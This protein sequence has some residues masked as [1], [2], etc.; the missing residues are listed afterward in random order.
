MLTTAD[1]A[2]ATANSANN[3]TLKNAA[4]DRIAFTASATPDG[5]AQFTQGGTIDYLSPS[6]L[7]L[8]GNTPLYL[9]TEPGANVSAGTYTDTLT[10]NWDW[11]ICTGIAISGLCLGRDR[12]TGTST[13]QISLVVTND[14][15]VSVPEIIFGAAAFPA[16]FSPVNHRFQISCTKGTIYYVGIDSGDHPSGGR[17]QMVGSNS[18]NK[19]Q[20]DIFNS[21][22]NQLWTDTVAG[23]VSAIGD[24]NQTPSQNFPFRASIYADQ[25]AQPA[26]IY[27]DQVRVNVYF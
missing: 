23:R 20:Y 2:K 24:G 15:R 10:L 21:Q 17:R 14:C 7:S 25:P 27:K 9:R 8:L 13:V 11:S 16:D 4:G 1:Y 26:G 3:F 18:A 22:T 6:I 12:G 5:S 19:L